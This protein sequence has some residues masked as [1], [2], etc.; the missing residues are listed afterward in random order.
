MAQ[1]EPITT[2]ARHPK[3]QTNLR[4][5]S[6]G[7]P[8]CPKCL[9]Q[10]PVGMKCRD[11]GTQRAGVLFTLSPGQAASA[12]AVG[13]LFG[14]VAGLGVAFFGFFMIF[15][16]VA[17]G[18]FAGEMIL[19]ASGRKRGVKIEVIAGVALAVGA[20]GGRMIVAALL[21]RAPG[22]IHPPLGVLDVIVGLVIPSPIPLIC[23]VIA[24]ASAVGRIRYI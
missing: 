11:C 22:G 3:V 10:T 21:M 4:C 18:T 12:L 6:C 23:L 13:L 20:I 5:A 16:A 8:I 19:R 24:I 15:L 2:C 7:T 17:Y 9:V 1:S 14:V